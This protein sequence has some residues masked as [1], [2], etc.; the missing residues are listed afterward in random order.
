[1]SSKFKMYCVIGDPIDHSLSPIMH[2]SAFKALGINS[3][4]ISYRVTKSELKRAVQSLRSIDISGFNVTIPHKID[5]IKYMDE[6]DESSSHSSAVN[7]VKNS[8]GKFIGYNT[9]VYGFVTPLHNRNIKFNG[10]KVLIL[11]AGGAAYAIVT[12]LSRECG[13]SRVTVFNRSKINALK[14]LKHASQL[15]LNCDFQEL[16]SLQNV[17]FRSNLI[18]NATS[19]GLNNEQ[20]P[21]SSKY[22]DK[23]TIVYDIVYSPIYTNL[24]KNARKAGATVI[25][26]YEMLLEQGA[27]AFK[28]WTGL[29]APLDVMKKSLLGIFGEP[30]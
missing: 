10:M 22:I 20:S 25:Y 3:S 2:N 26:G 9:D 15:G 28:I 21:I 30:L 23:N 4:Y 19:L 1:M 5:I 12:A 29:D 14:L 13:I 7:T 6:L 17:A 27:Q 8:H 11:G 18:I 24:I 16:D